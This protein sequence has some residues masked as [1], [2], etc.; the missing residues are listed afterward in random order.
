MW[1]VCSFFCSRD[2]GLEQCIYGYVL[3]QL[4]KSS[5]Q[6]GIQKGRSI[7]LYKLCMRFVVTNVWMR[8][9]HEKRCNNYIF[10]LDADQT[11]KKI[12]QKHT[13]KV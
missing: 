9:L 5:T 1:L 13:S 3:S 12:Q 7:L 8:F 11:N 10:I 6:N 4:L 2:C